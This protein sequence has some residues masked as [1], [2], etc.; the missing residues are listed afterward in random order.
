MG[1]CL[2][3]IYANKTLQIDLK[4]D[5]KVEMKFA[6]NNICEETFAS[7]DRIRLKSLSNVETMTF[8]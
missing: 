2:D 7:E 5:S 3:S 6:A 8:Y 1:C 4:I